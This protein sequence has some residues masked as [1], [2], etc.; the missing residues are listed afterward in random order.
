MNTEIFLNSYL[1]FKLNTHTID[2]TTTEA[3]PNKK[4][5][6]RKVPALLP[7]TPEKPMIN[8][9]ITITN[10]PVQIRGEYAS[11]IINCY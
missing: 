5:G 6:Y 8:P 2:P 9:E 10:I 11:I 4:K 1:L 3:T 7:S